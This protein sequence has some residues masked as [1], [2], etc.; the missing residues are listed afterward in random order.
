MTSQIGGENR[1]RSDGYEDG[2]V[3]EYY[4]ATWIVRE[5]ADLDFYLG[6]AAACCGPPGRGRDRRVLELGCGTGRVLLRLAESEHRVCGLDLSPHMLSR[7]REK[8][9]QLPRDV[10]ERVRLVAGDMTAFDLGEKFALIIIPFRPFQHL[11]AVEDQLACLAAA[12][13]HLAPGGRLVF[14]LFQTDARRMHDPLFLQERPV[15]GE[16]TLDDGRVVRVRERTIAF[17]RAMQSND[18]ELIYCVTHPDGRMERFPNPFRIRYFFRYEV[19]HL[20]ARAGFRV[21]E[22]FGDF[23]RAPLRDDSPDMIFIAEHAGA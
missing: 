11:L 4:D 5:R 13:R 3:A 23:T 9:S 16:V 18:V 22:L 8:L 7:C 6:C 20:L 2:F 21:A 15:P 19:E 12:K 10:Q 17:H 14:D 1:R